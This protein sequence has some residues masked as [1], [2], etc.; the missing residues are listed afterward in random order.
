MAIDYD[1]QA[2]AMK[3]YCDA[4]DNRDEF[5]GEWKEAWDEAKSIGWRTYKENDEWKHK[6]PDC[7]ERYRQSLDKN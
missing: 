6:C 7:V 3:V 1:N 2:E 5:I 4:C